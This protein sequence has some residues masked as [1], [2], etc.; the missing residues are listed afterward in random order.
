MGIAGDCLGDGRDS[1]FGSLFM[2]LTVL[3]RG[4]LHLQPWRCLLPD[5]QV[6]REIARQALPASFNIMSVALGFFV[7]TYFLKSYGEA[8]V[9]AFGVTTRIE[10]I[11]LLPTFGLYAAIM[12]LVGQN[13]GARNFDRIH[14]TMRLCNRLG[15]AINLST[16]LLIYVFAKQLMN[17]FT[18]DSEV[19]QIG[20]DC[21]HI[22]ALIQWSYVMTSTHLAMLQAIKRPMYGFFESVLRKVLLPLPFLWLFVLMCSSMSNGSGIPL[23]V[24]MYS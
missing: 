19:I 2:L 5:L 16:S 18:S 24:P 12:A 20:V 13:N 14:E 15:L 17:I 23:Q 10:Q 1:D 8:T 4:L 3:Q 9:A 22:I 21:I 6:Y 11:G 7:V